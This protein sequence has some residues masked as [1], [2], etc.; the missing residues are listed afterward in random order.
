MLC[1]ATQ[2]PS[3]KDYST[4]Q[5]L[6]HFA[7]GDVGCGGCVFV[8]VCVV[9]HKYTHRGTED[10]LP[11][12]IFIAEDNESETMACLTHSSHARSAVVVNM[13]PG[14]DALCQIEA[15]LPA[16]TSFPKTEI[17]RYL[18]TYSYVLLLPPQQPTAA[19]AAGPNAKYM[20]VFMS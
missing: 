8:C 7:F 9:F 15:R 10:V 5:C 13:R 16:Y 1:L 6:V 19:A 18:C 4:A 2:P 3:I 20:N 11:T 17:D 12:S 14:I